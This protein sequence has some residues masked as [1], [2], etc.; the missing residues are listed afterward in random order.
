MVF[1]HKIFE[2]I[3]AP[4][5][6]YIKRSQLGIPTIPGKFYIKGKNSTIAFKLNNVYHRPDASVASWLFIYDD[7]A[8]DFLPDSLRTISVEVYNDVKNI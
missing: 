5:K 3:S 8:G 4:N 6:L 2:Y 1:H 7:G